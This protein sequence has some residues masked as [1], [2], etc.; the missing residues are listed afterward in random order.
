MRTIK[1]TKEY[2]KKEFFEAVNAGK[3][4]GIIDHK[5]Y[6]MCGFAIE[7][8]CEKEGKVTCPDCIEQIEKCKRLVKGKDY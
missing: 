5:Q 6:T 3:T 8:T 4:H 2:I 7:E 1:F